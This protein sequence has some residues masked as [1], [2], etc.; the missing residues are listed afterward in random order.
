[1][2]VLRISQIEHSAGIEVHG[3]ARVCLFESKVASNNC[4]Y[5]HLVLADSGGEINAYG[6]ANQLRKE[7]KEISEEIVLITGRTKL[8]PRN[9]ELAID[10]YDI[11]PVSSATENPLLLYPLPEAANSSDVSELISI[12]NEI[13][14]NSLRLFLYEVFSDRKLLTIYLTGKGSDRHHHSEPGGLLRHSIEVARFVGRIDE[15]D[16]NMREVAIVAA[17]LHDIAKTRTYYN[18]H[19]NKN[20]FMVSHDMRTYRILTGSLDRLQKRWPDGAELFHICVES[21]IDRKKFMQTHKHIPAAAEV[22]SFGDQLS[23][24]L[25]KEQH[26]TQQMKYW[27]RQIKLDGEIYWRCHPDN[28]SETIRLAA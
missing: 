3:A 24:A 15:L 14:S 1:M 19:E 18:D 10:L 28:Y 12:I 2:S 16:G 20:S 13:S 27:Q 25:Y 23:T 11:A 5:K 6:W 8:L 26:A 7:I 4:E 21:L 22:V 17:L 9:N